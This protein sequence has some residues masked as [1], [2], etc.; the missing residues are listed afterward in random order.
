MTPVG[1]PA[2]NLSADNTGDMNYSQIF[3]A[4]VPVMNYDKWSQL[5]NRWFAGAVSTREYSDGVA[6]LL[7][8]DS[9]N[10]ANE[11]S[12]YVRCNYCGSIWLGEDNCRNCAAPRGR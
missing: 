7:D 5:R 3:F 4:E 10:L 2:L 11:Y 6:A 12:T 1:A 9:Y 8:G